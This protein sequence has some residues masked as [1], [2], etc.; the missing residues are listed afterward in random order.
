[1]PVS[2]QTTTHDRSSHPAGRVRGGVRWAV[3]PVVATWSVLGA[4][5]V[6]A[7]VVHASSDLPRCSVN[8]VDRLAHWDAGWYTL[9]AERGYVRIP[10]PQQPSAFFP[11]LP[12]LARAL[13]AVLPF[14]S[15]EACGIAINL[16]AVTA[17]MVI[18]DR[19]IAGWPMWQRVACVVLLLVLPGA[20][21]YTF[22]YS[23]ALFVLAVA[24]VAWALQRPERI[25]LAAAGVVVAS[26]D[27]S[28]GIILVVPVA[29]AA[30]RTKDRHETLAIVA[31]SCSGVALF[32]AWIVAAGKVDLFRDSRGGWRGAGG[33]SYPVY[34]VT[35][36]IGQSW[37]LV[38][39]AALG[40][41]VTT[42]PDTG[43]S[44]AWGLGLLMDV[45]VVGALAAL[46]RVRAT[47]RPLV[48]LAAVLGG[49]TLLAGPAISQIR[50]T[51][52][53]VPL[54]IAVIG[55]VRNRRRWYAGIAIAGAAS[56][57]ANVYLV[58]QF[59]A[60]RWAG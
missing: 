45:V 42:E 22:F 37:D 52:V 40:R 53:L 38:T 51:A 58:G 41:R 59:S 25:W 43:A 36:A 11:L 44:L 17:A 19:I 23:E 55:I 20:Y 28:I 54:W 5:L 31:A 13:H 9:I 32:G 1:M 56:L 60:C 48:V 24:L 14:L 46:R 10:G 27:R 47:E 39:N 16:A 15:I 50:F 34:F 26:L 29:I 30:W 18:V 7:L 33:L 2:Q 6:T 12:V 57:L 4:Y 8:G 3:A 21:F 35:H 49:A